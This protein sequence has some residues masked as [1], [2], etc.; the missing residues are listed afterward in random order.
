MPGMF[1]IAGIDLAGF[2]VDVKQH[3]AFEAMMLGQNPR[4][5]PAEFPPTDI[6][7]RLRGKRCASPAP[8]RRF[9]DERCGHGKF[10]TG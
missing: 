8:L 4:D 9:E 6:R 2:F 3:R 1:E 10:G 7:D 5:A